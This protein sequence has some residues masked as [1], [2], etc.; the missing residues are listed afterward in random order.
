[1]SK[2]PPSAPTASAVGL[3]KS[4]LVGRPG[5]ESLPSTIAPPDHPWPR[6]KRRVF[7]KRPK[8]KKGV[9]FTVVINMI[10]AKVPTKLQ[11]YKKKTQGHAHSVYAMMRMKTLS[12]EFIFSGYEGV[13]G[14]LSCYFFSFSAKTFCDP[15]LEPSHRDGSDEGFTT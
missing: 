11:S 9:F 12:A 15:S 6:P 5:T 2:Q 8:L 1:M 10:K 7:L 13:I 14:I 3:L 4:K